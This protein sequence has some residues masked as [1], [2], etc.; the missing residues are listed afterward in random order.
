M[1]L[2]NLPIQTLTKAD[3]FQLRRLRNTLILISSPYI[4][5]AAPFPPSKMKKKKD[6]KCYCGSD[7]GESNASDSNTDGRPT[8]VVVVIVIAR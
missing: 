3:L 2:A 6:R 5:I 1:R 4:G 7:S 8:F